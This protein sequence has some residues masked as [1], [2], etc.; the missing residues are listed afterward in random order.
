MDNG[1]PL[2]RNAGTHKKSPSCRSASATKLHLPLVL[3]HPLIH[4]EFVACIDILLILSDPTEKKNHIS[5]GQGSNPQCE[6]K[7]EAT[8]CPQSAKWNLWS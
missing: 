6:S 4:Q 2:S 7:S 5:M 1:H 8:E 3:Y